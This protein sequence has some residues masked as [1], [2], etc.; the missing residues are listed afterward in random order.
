MNFCYNGSDFKSLANLANQSTDPSLNSTLLD[1]D[2]W[3]DTAGKQLNVYDVLTTSFVL[4]GPSSSAATGQTGAIVASMKDTSF[5]PHYVIKEY[6]SDV[7][8]AIV[9]KDSFTPA[10]TEPTNSNFPYIYA[11]YT[12]TNAAGFKI[13]GTATNATQLENNYANAFIR[14]NIAAT[15]T[16]AVSFTSVNGITVGPTSDL[17]INATS[18]GNASITNQTADKLLSLKVK[19]S[20]TSYELVTLD[21]TYATPT[22]IL[23]GSLVVNADSKFIG[24]IVPN[25]TAI[26]DLG[27]ATTAFGTVYVNNVRA[28]SS[29]NIAL[30][31]NVMPTANNTIELGNTTYRFKTIYATELNVLTGAA[32]PDGSN[33]ES[34]III[35][36]NIITSVLSNCQLIGSNSITMSGNIIPTANIYTIGNSTKVFN[37][38]FG[39][40]FGSAGTPA[41][42]AYVNNVSPGSSSNIALGGNITPGTNAAY[43]LGTT[44]SRFVNIFTTNINSIGANI[45]GNATIGNLTVTGSFGI[46]GSG[47]ANSVS[48]GGGV[49]GYI[50]AGGQLTLGSTGSSANGASTIVT[51]GTDGSFAANIVTVGGLLSS[52]ANGTVSIGSTGTYFGNIF[53]TAMLAR[54]ADLAERYHADAEYDSGTVVRLGG[55][56]EI[57]H[58]VSSVDTTVFGVISTDPGLILNAGAGGNETHPLIALTGRVPCKVTGTVNKGDRLVSSDIPGVAKAYSTGD[59]VLAIIGRSLVNKTSIEVELIEIVVGVK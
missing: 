9:S 39:T 35:N 38:I 12:I 16:G 8:V 17:K 49:T 18:A 45:T 14:A 37:T 41:S 7:V 36:A 20:S 30:G 48:N 3:W 59:D 46:T 15:T 25:T 19:K 54:Y 1:G 55:L 27:N 52:G 50:T 40:N 43:Y 44:S 29:G 28:V 32:I 58:T 33:L 57:T 34:P 13:V 22:V 10:G 5:I 23:N 11:G 24:N 21:P 4:I 26:Y 42:I 47:F 2:L 56:H 53:G 31:S 6:V 51:R